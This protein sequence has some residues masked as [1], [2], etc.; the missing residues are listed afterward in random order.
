MNEKDNLLKISIDPIKQASSALAAS[1]FAMDQSRQVDLSRLREDI[2]TQV[3]A[4]QRGDIS[5]IE[6]A[7]YSQAMVLQHLFNELASYAQLTNNANVMQTLTQTALK[8]Q[9][10]CRVTLATLVDLRNPRQ[11]TFI[12]Q[13]NN[14]INQQINNGSQTENLEKMANE[15]LTEVN[16][17]ALD[18][19]G[20]TETI[21]I[22]QA[23]EAM[24]SID[25]GEDALW[26]ENQLYE[27]L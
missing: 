10:Q 15:L 25:R 11:A 16:H 23:V 12:K 24:A 13:Q 1:R 8:A 20:T 7:L 21:G 22:N 5:Q 19:R 14:A 6:T 2:T 18:S 3:E 17:A 27:R 4:I 9:N 26:Q